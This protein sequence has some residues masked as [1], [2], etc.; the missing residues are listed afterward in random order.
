MID[1]IILIVIPKIYIN[2]IYGMVY[3]NLAKIN[4]YKLYNDRQ[5]N[6]SCNTKNIY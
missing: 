1:N 5:Y 6:I 2:S 3:A 4:K